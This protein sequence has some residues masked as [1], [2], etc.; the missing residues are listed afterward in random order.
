MLPSGA[1][2]VTQRAECSGGRFCRVYRGWFGSDSHP[3]GFI[4]A[5]GKVELGLGWLCTLPP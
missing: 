5:P 4:R 1:E 3:V 2:H